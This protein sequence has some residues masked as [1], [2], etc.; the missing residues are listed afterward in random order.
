MYKWALATYYW[1]VTLR[2]TDSPSRG[3]VAIL[4]GRRHARETRISSGLLGLW[5]VCDFTWR[6]VFLQLLVVIL[7]AFELVFCWSC[8]P[9]NDCKYAACMLYRYLKFHGYELSMLLSNKCT[10][11]LKAWPSLSECFYWLHHW[12]RA[13]YPKLC[14]ILNFSNTIQFLTWYLYDWLQWYLFRRLSYG[15][16]SFVV[17]IHKRCWCETPYDRFQV[18]FVILLAVLREIRNLQQ[19][20]PTRLKAFK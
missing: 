3:T 10:G 14:R 12:I 16:Y 7:Q 5:L 17:M 18:N 9:Y 20:N 2:W 1:G 13:L 15:K 19:P 8:A 4:L 11:F 6:L